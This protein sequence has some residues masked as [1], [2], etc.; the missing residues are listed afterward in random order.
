M[1]GQA[2]FLGFALRQNFMGLACRNQG[3]PLQ[4]LKNIVIVG[5]LFNAIL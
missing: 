5:Y 4:Q 3:T 1:G 2:L